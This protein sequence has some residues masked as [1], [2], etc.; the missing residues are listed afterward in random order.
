MNLKEQ[1]WVQAQVEAVARE[2]TASQRGVVTAQ[3]VVQDKAMAAQVAEATEVRVAM[4]ALPIVAEA[5]AVAMA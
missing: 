1:A 3:M 5:V 2:V 4:E